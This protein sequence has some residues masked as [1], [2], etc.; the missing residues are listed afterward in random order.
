VSWLVREFTDI[1]T[2]DEA[3][4]CGQR[5]LEQGVIEHFRRKHG[6]LDGHYFYQ[7]VGETTLPNTPRSRWWRNAPGEDKE[8]AS[9]I[10]SSPSP[11]AA[12][13][14]RLILSQMMI[15]DIDPPPNRKSERAEVALLHHDIIHNAA[16]C[17]HFEL[18]W[19]ANSAHCIEDML[20]S[21]QSRIDKYGLKL[22]EAYVD[23]I[24]SVSNRNPFQ[25]FYP[26]PLVLPPPEIPSSGLRPHFFENAILIKKF[27][28]VLDIE[29]TD[30]YPEHIDVYYSY[31]RTP[32]QYSQ[33]VHKS[34]VAFV[35]LI[36]GSEGFRFLTNR[37]YAQSRRDA[38]SAKQLREQMQEFCCDVDALKTF[39]DITMRDIGG[40]DALPEPP[41]LSI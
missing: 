20:K 3:V 18:H 19:I 29:A 32:F 14:K 35:Q 1:S 16:T 10:V 15:L 5:L 31:R 7:I 39:Y 21:W 25:S 27:G 22:V 23:E 8:K 40:I 30:R 12:R 41:P 36:G 17:F 4:Q 2:R 9:A 33:Y 26:I 6:F 13:K 24:S 28:F 37:L 38:I 11:E 34:G